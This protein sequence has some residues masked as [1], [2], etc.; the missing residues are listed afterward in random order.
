MAKKQ[1]LSEDQA[2]RDK[3]DLLLKDL[4]VQTEQ[5]I[6]DKERKIDA[7]STSITTMYKVCKHIRSKYFQTLIIFYSSL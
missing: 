1:S 7:V 6:K 2:L 3:V 4:E 5:L